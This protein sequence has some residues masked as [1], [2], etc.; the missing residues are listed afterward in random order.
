M[1]LLSILPLLSLSLLSI[2][3]ATPHPFIARRAAVSNTTIYAYG[4]NISGLPLAYG[5][6][7]GLAYI[8]ATTPLP[9]TLAAITWDITTDTSTSW[10]A[11]VNA[12]LVGSLFISLSQSFAA[13]GFVGANNCKPSFLLNSHTL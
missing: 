3:S 6:S 7:D 12:T 4:T 2:T 9:T 1:H 10:N 11:T 13:V 5:I 8:S